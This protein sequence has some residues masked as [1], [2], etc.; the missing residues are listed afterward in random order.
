MANGIKD[1]YVGL[2]FDRYGSILS[3]KQRQI[4]ECYYNDDLSLS[5]IAENEGITRQ[6]VSDVLRR[7]E[8]QLREA[9]EEIGYLKLIKVLKDLSATATEDNDFSKLINFIENI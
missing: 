1:L 8:K 7:A 3:S 6:A 9:E 4:V 2:L 5:E